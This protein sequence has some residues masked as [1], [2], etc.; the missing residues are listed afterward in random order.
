MTN[1]KRRK[2]ARTQINKDE[3]MT[4]P[5]IVD[6]DK[7]YQTK[8]FKIEF[9]VDKDATPEEIR[10]ACIDAFKKYWKAEEQKNEQEMLRLFL[11]S[12]KKGTD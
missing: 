3:I 2:I 10:Q 8:T 7:I 4:V 9:T 5:P 1:K 12:I 6:C 11:E